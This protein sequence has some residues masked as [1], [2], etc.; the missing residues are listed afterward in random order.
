MRPCYRALDI[1]VTVRHHPE[2]MSM[3]EKQKGEAQFTM[4]DILGPM[5]TTL[6]REAS[7]GLLP[8]AEE[9]EEPVLVLLEDPPAV[10]LGLQEIGGQLPPGHLPE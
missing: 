6:S 7:I 3:A 10:Q 4:S 1:Q 5:L 8:A 2:G 9:I